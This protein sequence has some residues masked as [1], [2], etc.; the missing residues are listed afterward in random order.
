VARV[1]FGGGLLVDGADGPLSE[2]LIRGY[3]GS[4]L[5]QTKLTEGT[6]AL[7]GSYWFVALRNTQVA[8]ARRVVR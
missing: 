7:L 4:D 5:S 1:A 8:R 3:W 6:F 2:Q